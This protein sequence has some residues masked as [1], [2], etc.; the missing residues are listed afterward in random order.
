MSAADTNIVPSVVCVMVV[1]EPGDWFDETLQALAAQD[2]PN[3]RTLFLLSPAPADEIAD[4]TARIR[5]VIP[6]AFVREA[7]LAGGF[8]PTAN[9]V[10]RLVE[11]LRKAVMRRLHARSPEAARP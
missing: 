5:S 8:G 11:E 7:Q 10:L 6:G 1:H 3:F 2:Y 4:T 9:E